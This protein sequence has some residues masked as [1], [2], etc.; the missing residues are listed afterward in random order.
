MQSLSRLL[1]QIQSH[2]ILAILV[3][4]SLRM[5]TRAVC[6]LLFFL[7]GGLVFASPGGFLVYRSRIIKGNLLY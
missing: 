1:S 4:R 2:P 6:G 7:G 5:E 3:P